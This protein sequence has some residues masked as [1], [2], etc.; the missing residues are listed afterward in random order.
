M[1]IEIA[2]EGKTM[3]SLVCPTAGRAPFYLLFEKNNLVKTI[4]NPF[5]VGGGGAGFGVVQ[6]LSNEGVT[7]VVSGKFGDNLLSALRDKHMKHEA[8]VGKTVQEALEDLS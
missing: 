3:D 8:M 1:K 2:A 5:A 6:M 7:T 4:K